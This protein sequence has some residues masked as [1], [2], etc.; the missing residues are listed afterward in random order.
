VINRDIARPSLKITHRV[1]TLE[2]QF[3]DQVVRLRDNVLRVVDE[4]A[5]QGVP[6]LAEPGSVC[7]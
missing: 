2:H 3:T 4:T 6:S 1:A 7:R 5:L